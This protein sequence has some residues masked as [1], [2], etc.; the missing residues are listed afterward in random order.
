MSKSIDF[1][2][3]LSDEDKQYLLDR[4]RGHLIPDGDSPSEASEVE[5][6][7]ADGT[8]SEPA[9]AAEVE[10]DEDEEVGGEFGAMKVEEL[11]ALLT[12]RDLPTDGKK[13][14]LVAR[15]ESAES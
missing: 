10:S 13:A 8:P 4:N 3:P 1:S 11:K 7:E 12:A 5:T 9:D 15:L 2:Q 14:D 6:A